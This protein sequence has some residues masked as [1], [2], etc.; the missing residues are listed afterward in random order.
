MGNI[1]DK[2]VDNL[3]NA[4]LKVPEKIRKVYEGEGF[5]IKMSEEYILMKETR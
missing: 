1:Y 2:S 4:Y 3:M 5:K